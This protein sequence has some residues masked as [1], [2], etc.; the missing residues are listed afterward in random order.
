MSYN[1]VGQLCDCAHV[2]LYQSSVYM[3]HKLRGQEVHVR[4]TLTF[5]TLFFGTALMC[6]LN[7]INYYLRFLE[8]FTLRDLIFIYNI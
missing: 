5:E 3:N 4:N 2:Y 8:S 6:S 7:F 1:N